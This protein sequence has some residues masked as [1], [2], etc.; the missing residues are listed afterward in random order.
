MELGSEQVDVAV[1][2][3]D[4]DGRT[5]SEDAR[6]GQVARVDG[7][8]EGEVGIAACAHIPNRGEPGLERHAS[9]AGADQ[10]LAR[11]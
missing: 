3:R 2:A 1:A 4:A 6:A 5:R 10:G 8:T 11:R 7:V 9:V